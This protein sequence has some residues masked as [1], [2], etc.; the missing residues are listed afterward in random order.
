MKMSPQEGSVVMDLE[1]LLSSSCRRRILK[2]LSSN[3]PT[4]VMQLIQKVNNTYN[5]V[6]SSL[7]ILQK[8]GIIID[9]RFG[10]MRVIRLN[11]ENQRTMIML[12][13]LKIL[14]NKE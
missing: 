4:N 13:A 3:G 12:R 1:M 9:E 2:V 5:H 6:N 7:Q 11:K 10:R 8:E 14:E